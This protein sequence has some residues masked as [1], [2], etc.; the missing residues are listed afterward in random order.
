V[1]TRHFHNEDWTCWKEGVLFIAS[2]ESLWKKQLCTC[3]HITRDAVIGE[4]CL[5]CKNEPD[6]ESDRYTVA[7]K[8]DGI[9]VGHLPQKISQASRIT[10]AILTLHN[11]LASLGFCPFSILLVLYNLPKL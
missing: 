7:V 10:F 1:A 6:N 11:G 3:Y 9:I 8:K 5:K 4:E 2:N